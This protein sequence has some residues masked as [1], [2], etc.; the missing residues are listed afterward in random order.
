MQRILLEGNIGAG[1]ST[2]GRKIN[3]KIVNGHKIE[4]LKEP[5]AQ[6]TQ[7]PQGNLL[8]K[9]SADPQSRASMFQVLAMETMHSSRMDAINSSSQ[10][11]VL[12]LEERSIYSS[13]NVFTQ[14]NYLQGDIS[15]DNLYILDCLFHDYAKNDDI[16]GI[17]YLDCNIETAMS[18]ISDRGH[19]SD[20]MLSSDY[21]RQVDNVYKT[22]LE[23]APWPVLKVN[24]SG[25]T[26]SVQTSV[27]EALESMLHHNNNMKI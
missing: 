2:L 8:A 22:W 25:S 13:R 23:Q 17:V 5:V 20:A 6:W 14:I 15:E 10:E 7:T 21:V 19:T 26:L 3:G 24:A 16:L 18:R 9:C 12:F 27:T 11:Q 1:K 4:Y